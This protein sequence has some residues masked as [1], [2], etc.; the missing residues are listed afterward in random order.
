MTRRLRAGLL[1]LVAALPLVASGCSVIDGGG[2]YDVIA[3]FPRAVSLYESGGV[4]VLGLPAG[5]VTDIEIVG[6]VVRVTMG[7]DD[8]VP[9]PAD[10]KAAIVPQSLIGERR[11]QLFPPYQEGDPVVSDGHEIA[12]EDTVIPVE[13]DEALAALEEFLR[14]LDPD[15]LGRLIDNT[16][17]ALDG[18]G[19]NLGEALDEL[20]ELVGNVEEN[21]DDIIAIA[22]RFDDFTETLLTRESQLAEALDDFAVVAEVLADERDSIEQLV[23]GLASASGG[24]LDLVSEHAVR[25]RTDVEILTRL[26]RSIDTNL[27]SVQDLLDAGPAIVDGFI[28]A[29]NPELR[30]LD[31]R[32]NFTPIVAEGLSGL[33]VGLGL[34]DLAFPCVALLGTDCPEGGLIE[35]GDLSVGGLA[36]DSEAVPSELARPTTPIDDIVALFGTPTALTVDEGGTPSP[37]ASRGLWDRLVGTFLG[38]GS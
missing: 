36:G 14:Q 20:S 18:Q 8:D 9:L 19:E 30:A 32:N 1:S 2:T 17:S 24:G 27:D 5:E 25:L 26:A 11:I 3:Y 37:Q 10:V 4:Q 13:P 31:L 6:D 35:I 21:D 16:A 34:E 15:G 23:T 29:Y 28:D 7:V 38:V 22:E 33:L 12:I